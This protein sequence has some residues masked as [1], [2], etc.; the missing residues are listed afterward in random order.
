[1]ATVPGAIL[2]LGQTNQRCA[3][4]REAIMAISYNVPITFG[5]NGS[6]KTLNCSGI[7]FSEAGIQSWTSASQAELEV[8]LPPARQEVLVQI[9]ASPFIIPTVVESQQV[10]IF[11]CGMFVGF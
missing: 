7:D 1:M 4:P 9:E 10:F 2:V 8:Q 3:C 6:A 5:R 11:L